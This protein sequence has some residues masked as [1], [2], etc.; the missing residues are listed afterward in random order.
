MPKDGAYVTPEHKL[1]PG[2]LYSEEI[3]FKGLGQNR[4]LRDLTHQELDRLFSGT[5]FV[6]S[7]HAITRLKDPRTKAIGLETS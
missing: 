5:G 6:L 3:K 4:P 1:N 2:L 7:N